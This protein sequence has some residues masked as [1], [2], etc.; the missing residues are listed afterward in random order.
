MEVPLVSVI[1]CTY[2]G[3]AYLTEQL[4]SLEQQTYSSLEIICSDN[5][6]TD[7]TADILK[8][9]CDNSSNRTFISFVERG[10]NKNFFQALNYATGDY[11]IFCDQDD[12]WLPEK[13]EKLVSFHQQNSEASLV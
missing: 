1:M 2:Q 3:A 10:L 5:I 12:I 11:V 9:W 4:Q 8:E 13:I 6:S 7:G